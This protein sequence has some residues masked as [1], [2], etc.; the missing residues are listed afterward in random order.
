MGHLAYLQMYFITSRVQFYEKFLLCISIFFIFKKTVV[1]LFYLPR[2]PSILHNVY[3]HV[4]IVFHDRVWTQ[5]YYVYPFQV[6]KWH[7]ILILQYI[8]SF[9]MIRECPLLLMSAVHSIIMY[10][11]R[12]CATVPTSFCKKCVLK[13]QITVCLFYHFVLLV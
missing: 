2:Q 4:P 6:L 13:F 3:L 9:Y 12:I 8:Y 5:T 7:G 1:F 11:C 10:T